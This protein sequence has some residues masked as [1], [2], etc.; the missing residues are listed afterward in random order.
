MCHGLPGYQGGNRDCQ[1]FP[2]QPL[3][4][5]DGKDP[6]CSNETNNRWWRGSRAREVRTWLANEEH[7]FPLLGASFPTL[8]STAKVENT[9][10]PVKFTHFFKPPDLQVK[11][12]HLNKT[13]C[14]PPVCFWLFF[15]YL[16]TYQKKCCDLSYILNFYFIT[17]CYIILI[18]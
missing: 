5:L 4:S 15:W 8:L 10:M 17:H 12:F 16:L 9:Q 6:L 7:I 14:G 18:L 2:S 13:E 1:K 11:C 3:K